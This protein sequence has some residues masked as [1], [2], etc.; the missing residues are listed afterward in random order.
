MK[1]TDEEQDNK[2]KRFYIPVDGKYYETTEEIYKVYYSM[3]RRE[4]YLEERDIK[5]GVMNFSDL[6][7]D[8]YKAEEMISDKTVDIENEIT[9]K[10]MIEAVF[11]AITTL[12]EEEKWL[13][14]ELFFYGKSEVVV[15]KEN[16]M[17]RTTIQSK[18]YKLIEKIKKQLKF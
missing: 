11:D 17:A 4:R 2:R 3:D 16:C 7:N 13:I 18:K 15:A 6:D 5:K 14:Q 10:I 8:N 1:N 12:E 9:N